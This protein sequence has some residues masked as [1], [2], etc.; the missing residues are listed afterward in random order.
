MEVTELKFQAAGK[1]VEHLPVHGK[2]CVLDNVHHMGK[3]NVIQHGDIHH[4]Y[5]GILPLDGYAKAAVC[6]ITAYPGP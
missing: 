1:T 3:G 4:E 5:A 6:S 2:Q